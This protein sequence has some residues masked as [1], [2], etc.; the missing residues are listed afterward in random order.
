M[1][2]QSLLLTT[3]ALLITFCSA[4]SQSNNCGG[5]PT[6]L[7]V[8][9]AC[10][11]QTFNNNQNGTAQTVNASCAG[12]YGSAFEDSW[13]SV[14][15]TGN[16]MTITL[17]GANRDAVLSAFTGCGTGELDCA[18]IDAG[19][20]G[21][22]TFATTLGTTYFIQIQRRS[23]NNN[24]D[25][26]GDICAVSAPGGG[27]TNDTPCTA[28][29]LAVATA[30]VNISGDN[31]GATDSGIADP[32]CAF[33]SG[34]DVWYSLIVPASGDVNVTTSDNGGFF[35]GGLALYS[36]TCGAPVLEACDDDSNGAFESITLTGQTPGAT[37]FVRVWEF[38]GGTGGTF[39]ICAIDPPPPPSNVNCNIPDPICSGSPIVFTAQ[40]NGTDADIVN[41]GNDYDCLFSSPNPSWYYLEISG[42]GNLA[43]DITAGSDVD[44][45][46]WGPYADLATAVANCD[47]HP[48]PI[49][50][51]YSTSATEQ[52]NINGVLVGEVYVLLVTNFANSIQTI[53]LADAGANTATT[54]CSIVPLPIELINFQGERSGDE[55]QLSWTTLSEVNN[56]YFAVERSK[57]GTDWSAFAFVEG[58]GTSIE[59]IDY[60]TVDRNAGEGTVY[61]RLKQF[62]FNGQMTISD[63]ISISGSKNVD[64]TLYP[65]P[66]KNLVNV[67]ANSFFSQIIISDIT[68]KEVLDVKYSL[69]K[70]TVIDV[71]NL[72]KGIYQVNIQT[73]DENVVERLIIE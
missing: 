18:T 27:V 43:I 67:E 5:T 56:D 57:N 20:S 36:G 13:Y 29:P 34:A 1:K 71:S 55:I 7:P 37:I 68:G 2:F 62:D 70:S 31:T 25:L 6:N 3:A 22:V 4:F 72:N 53:T 58:N 14:T 66:A 60:A 65:N 10:T 61:Y 33:Y 30:C 9:G 44:F 12:G 8:N 45:A 24:Q 64:V 23:G 52:A 47:N 63:V 49:D 39:D 28:S 32:G 50:C 26:N 42:A 35:D 38:G 17:S 15:G 40:S 41:P 73:Q 54:D 19:N 21:S 69:I 16:A 59:S 51:S 46:L 48:L 11:T